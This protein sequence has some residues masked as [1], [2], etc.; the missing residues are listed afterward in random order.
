[1]FLI[2][3]S[4]KIFSYNIFEVIDALSQEQ[5]MTMY[6]QESTALAFLFDAT[7]S[8]LIK[9]IKEI[10]FIFLIVKAN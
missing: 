1:M 7:N 5:K 4:L 10:Q 2:S 3:T 9:T 8:Y 6:C